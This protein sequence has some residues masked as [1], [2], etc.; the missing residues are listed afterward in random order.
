M[1]RKNQIISLSLTLALLGLNL[2]AFNM[3]TAGWSTARLD[4]TQDRVYSTSGATKRI[5]GSLDDTLL[6]RGYENLSEHFEGSEKHEKAEESA[7]ALE[8]ARDDLETIHGELEA[9]IET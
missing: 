2:I 8:T 6:I 4:L 1:N 5:L 7:D 9:V 3:L